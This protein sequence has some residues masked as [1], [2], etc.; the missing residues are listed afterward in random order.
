MIIFIVDKF[1]AVDIIT[2]VTDLNANRAM[3]RCSMAHISLTC[4]CPAVENIIQHCILVEV[5]SIRNL[6]KSIRS[7]SIIIT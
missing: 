4:I 3:T 7:T 1:E 6:S 5:E 2:V